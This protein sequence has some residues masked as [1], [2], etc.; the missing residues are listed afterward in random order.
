[1]KATCFPGTKGP[2]SIPVILLHGFSGKEKASR[3]DFTQEQGLASFLQEKLGCFVIVPDLRGHGDSTKI[4][5]RQ[6][7]QRSERQEVAT[8]ANLGDGDARPA[9]REG[10]PLE[11]E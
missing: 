2:E 11:E 5:V 6:E 1:M 9:G 10:L 3:K 7:N 8:G 4:K